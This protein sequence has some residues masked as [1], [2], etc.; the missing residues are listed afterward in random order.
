MLRAVR[1]ED[2]KQRIFKEELKKR[3]YVYIPSK[4]SKFCEYKRKKLEKEKGN[5]IK[6]VPEKLY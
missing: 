3:I 1:K 5:A 4:D 6:R 2:E